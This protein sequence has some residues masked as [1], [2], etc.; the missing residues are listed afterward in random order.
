MP[1]LHWLND[2][3]AR[4]TVRGVP[5]RLLE[6][7]PALSFGDSSTQNMLIRGDNLDALKALL[8]YYTRQVKCIYIVIWSSL[9]T[10]F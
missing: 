6:E 2:N 4:R 8:P 1:T 3:E 9:S 10:V 5:Y 7:D